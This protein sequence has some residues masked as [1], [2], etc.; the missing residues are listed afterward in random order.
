MRTIYLGTS[1]FA[2]AV[3]DRL[4]DG[5]HRPVLVVTRPDRPRGRGRVPGPPPAAVR[6]RELA[7]D[8]IQPE[9]LHDADVLERIDAAS[10]DVL[11]VCAYGVLIKEPLLSSYEMLNVHPSL[12]P[13]W[14][15]A[16]PVERAIMAGDAETG[17]SI[18]RLTEG[19]DSGPVCAQEREPIRADDDY[20][21]LA[22]RLRELGGEVLVRALDERPPFVEQDEAGV[23]YAHKI[24][25][26]DRALDPTRTPEEVARQVRA[27]RPHIGARLPLPDGSYL[28]VI[29]AEVD[30]ETVAPAG[31]RLRTDEGRL[32]LD[33]NGGAL[34][35]T[36]VQPPGGR[37]MA[38]ADW[39]RGRP[40]PGLTNFWLDPRLPDRSLEELV[41][42]AVREWRSDAEWPPYLAALAWRGDEA[43]LDAARGLLE[44]ESPRERA[45]G[46]YVLGQLGIPERTHPAESAAALEALARRESDPE[47]LATLAIALGNLGS[48]HGTQTLLRLRRHEDAQVRDGAA[49]AMAGRDE[50]GV[51][52][53]LIE[54]TA[55]PQPGI[56]DWATFALGTL[57]T[58]DTPTL[59][60]ALAARLDDSDDDT[61]IEAVHGLALRGDTRALDA[62]LDLLGEVGPH[63]DGGNAADTIWKKYALTQATVRLAA[64]T[65]DPRLKAH[66][67]ALDERLMGTAIEGDLRR[68][69]ERVAEEA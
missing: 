28:G 7:I 3:L 57:S 59:R 19:L 64:L 61:R 18:M 68:A 16:A 2:A 41:E 30:G 53:A 45:V 48:P 55:D 20:G 1:D 22:A 58:Q 21:T 50:S 69:I 14:R 51:F 65:G 62:V 9:R 43:V 33:C 38:A 56:R 29:A 32:L 17:V 31:G 5:P 66:L 12:L 47:V 35:L 26:R 15:G 4:A 24:E 54:L 67:P 10:P 11:V 23:T 25:A 46:A 44:H 37:S 34:E 40:D 39:L 27:L 52:E 42:L 60:D 36:Q 6:A 13:R 8:L 49:D 63:D